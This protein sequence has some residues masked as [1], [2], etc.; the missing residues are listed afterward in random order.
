[1]HK[2]L[3]IGSFLSK[4]RG[5]K[6]VGESLA[7]LLEHDGIHIELVS[8]FENKVL[9]MLDVIISIL[10]YKGLKVHIDV[11]SGN[12]FRIADL[13]S[14]IAKFRNKEVILTLHGGKLAE[15]AT[16]QMPMVKSLFHRASYI[17]TPSL[18][19]Q[20]YF[21]NE[22]FHINYLPNP[23]KLENF[24]FSREEVKKYSLL[25][26]RGFSAIYN[27][28]VPIK[29][30][31]TLKVKF[32]DSRLTMIGPDRGLLNDCRKLVA[33]LGLSNSVQFVGSIPNNE[34][35]KYYQS[36]EVYLNTTSYESFGV[37]VIEAAS[38]GIPIVSNKVGEIPFLWKDKVNMLMV[39]N[40]NIDQYVESIENIFENTELSKK[41]S[42][43]ARI[44]TE[45]FSWDIMK[46]YWINLL[47]N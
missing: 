7:E 30:L 39:E 10:F 3:F 11:F 42:L 43:N 9:R 27:P 41:L 4:T 37:A 16:A 6:G 25:W 38:C 26:V 8:R 17:Q 18:F 15:F 22:G 12:A 23:L 20:S 31:N 5:T 34:L 47:K 35:Y 29:I 24:P 33:D 14:R 19:L 44:K 36:H 2:I 46:T 21:Q 32:P 45:S 28:E 1:M 13:A 40:N